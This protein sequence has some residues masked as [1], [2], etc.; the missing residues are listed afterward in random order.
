MAM[1][2]IWRTSSYTKGDSCVEVADNNPAHVLVRDTKSRE[3]GLLNLNPGSWG[4][5][6]EAVKRVP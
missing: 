6:I 4:H 1:Q 5:F 3:S 2:S